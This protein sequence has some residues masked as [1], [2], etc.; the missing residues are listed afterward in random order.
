MNQIDV[1]AASTVAHNIITEMQ[2][3]ERLNETLTPKQDHTADVETE[4]SGDQDLNITPVDTEPLVTDNMLRFAVDTHSTTDISTTEIDFAQEMVN[5][6]NEFLHGKDA[7]NITGIHVD[8]HEDLISGNHTIGGFMIDEQISEEQ[9]S[10]SDEEKIDNFVDM[11][12]SPQESGDGFLGIDYDGFVSEQD[13]GHDDTIV[14]LEGSGS[15][16]H[17]SSIE[18]EYLAMDEY[19]LIP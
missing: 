2:T 7:L 9:K 13:I 17:Y 1:T 3:D 19:I 14:D 10:Q 15:G 16:D 18:D 5:I 12:L 11:E 6:E 8:P 4:L